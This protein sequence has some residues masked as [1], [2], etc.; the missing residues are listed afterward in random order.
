VK[1]AIFHPEARAF[2]P[3]PMDRVGVGEGRLAGKD[4]ACA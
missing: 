3:R 2:G 4:H 1:E